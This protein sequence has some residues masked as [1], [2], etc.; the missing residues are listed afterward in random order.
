[1][2][3]NEADFTRTFHSL[4]REISPP[5]TRENETTGS[6]FIEEIGDTPESQ[7][8]LQDWKARLHSETVNSADRLD[9]MRRAN[10]FII[11]RNHLIERV[12]RSAEDLSDFTPFHQL[13]VAL[14]TPFAINETTT[15]FSLAPSREQRI[16]NTFCGT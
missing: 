7:A 3:K 13:H 15:P 6:A 16:Q 12:I 5:D 11:P 1:M 14:Q 4:I 9:V 2:Q 10:P 8:W